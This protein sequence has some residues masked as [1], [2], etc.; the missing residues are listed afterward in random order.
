MSPACLSNAVRSRHPRLLLVLLG[1]IAAS[2]AA[3]G[4]L[5]QPAPAAELAPCAG[6]CATAAGSAKACPALP[7]PQDEV[8]LISSRGFSCGVPANIGQALTY[9][10]YDAGRWLPAKHAE[11]AAGTPAARVTMFAHGNDIDLQNSVECGWS[12][13]AAQITSEPQQEPVR[14]VIYSWPSEK[15]S[16]R[17]RVDVQS[18]CA[19]ADIDAFCMAW[20]IDAL[21]P[22]TPLSLA[23]Y[24]LGSRIVGGAQELVAGGSID[25]RPLAGLK[26]RQRTPARV[27]HMAAA[28]DNDSLLPGRRYGLAMNGTEHLVLLNNS[29]DHAL[30]FYPSLYCRNCG[31]DALGYSGLACPSWLGAAQAKLVQ[32]DVCCQIGSEHNWMHYTRVPSIAVLLGRGLSSAAPPPTPA[33]SAKT[34]AADLQEPSTKPTAMRDQAD[35]Q[36]SANKIFDALELRK[37]PGFSRFSA[38]AAGSWSPRYA[39]AL[40]GQRELR[41]DC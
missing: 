37:L 1:S 32:Y 14:F 31:P 34:A 7:R 10:R 3:A 28:I 12:V 18:K 19:R 5:L 26:H 13:Y 8:W 23:G 9:W 29:C 21:E 38:E 2:W 35:D 11:F 27:V 20:L 41:E 40:D 39:R 17:P 30:R 22:T 33:A 6:Q 4:S 24:S 15:I 36:D 16:R 25:G